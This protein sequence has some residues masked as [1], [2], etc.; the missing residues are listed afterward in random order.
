MW[1]GAHSRGTTDT[2]FAQAFVVRARGTPGQ[3]GLPVGVTGRTQELAWRER[4]SGCGALS[5]DP[6]LTLDQKVGTAGTRCGRCPTRCA[7][8]SEPKASGDILSGSFLGRDIT[9]GKGALALRL[10]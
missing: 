10:I 9:P 7:S 2:F 5:R 6:E 1:K 3:K 4:P 8:R